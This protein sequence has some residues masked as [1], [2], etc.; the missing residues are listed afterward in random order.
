MRRLADILW[1]CVERLAPA[2]ASDCIHALALEK[3]RA[4]QA[5]L[6]PI[7]PV[8]A[9]PDWTAENQA[10]WRSFLAG[11]TGQALW[12][13]AQAVGWINLTRAAGVD[14]KPEAVQRAGGFTEALDYLESLS[15]VSLRVNG[16]ED[17]GR[18]KGEP[19][20]RERFTP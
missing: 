5:D 20:I 9:A 6:P 3:Q 2:A 1:R 14:A 12:Q 16:D 17:T 4:L 11:P 19:G 7:L 15:R 18:P 10:Q 8:Q 13:R